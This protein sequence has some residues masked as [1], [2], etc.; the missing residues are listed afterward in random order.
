MLRS[1]YYSS[2]PF[3]YKK[4]LKNITFSPKDAISYK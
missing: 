2:I 4:D 3:F 1:E